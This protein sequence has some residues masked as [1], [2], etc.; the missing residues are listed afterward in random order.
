VIRFV[1]P[2]EE[3]INKFANNFYQIEEDEPQD[4]QSGNNERKFLILSKQ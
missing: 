4:W 1:K 3:K 2:E